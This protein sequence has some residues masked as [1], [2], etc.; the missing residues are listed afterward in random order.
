MSM[1]S[2]PVKPAAAKEMITQL[3]HQWSRRR[4]KV[5][6]VALNCAA[7][8]EQL[9]E[10]ELF[11]HESGAFTGA[12]AHRQLE[13]ADGG[14]LFLDEI[15]SM[16]LAQQVKL[17]RVLRCAKSPRLG[18][19]DV[20]PVDLRV[21]AAAKIDLGDPA[22][23]GDFQ[24]GSLDYR[25]NCRYRSPF[26]RCGSAAM[27]SHCCSPIWFS[28]CGSTFSAARSRRLGSQSVRPPPVFACLA[29][30]CPRAPRISRNG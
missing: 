4:K 26:H 10:A 14:T 5:T 16:P 3:L 24:R 9:F 27:I 12:Q 20:R 18:T 29:R 21:V 13:H 17:L 19:N 23:R 11:G 22:V 2:S 6:F 25:L 15:E 1:C 8:P 7:I 28:A 30:Q